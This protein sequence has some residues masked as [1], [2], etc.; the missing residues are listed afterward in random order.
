MAERNAEALFAHAATGRPIV[1]CEPSCLSAVCE[2]APALLRGEARRKAEAIST[3][4][5]NAISA[6]GSAIED[7]A[8]AYRRI[9]KPRSI[10]HSMRCGVGAGISLTSTSLWRVLRSIL[11]PTIL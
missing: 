5:V 9:A 6:G 7:S 10:R 3:E 8:R 2:D 11:K 1:F 4:R